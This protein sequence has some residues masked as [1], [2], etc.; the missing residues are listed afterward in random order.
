MSAPDSC[1]ERAHEQ[2]A[3]LVEKAGVDGRDDDEGHHQA[4]DA[5]DGSQAGCRRG[6]LVATRVVCD[7]QRPRDIDGGTR[8]P[9]D[10]ARDEDAR[11]VGGEGEAGHGQGAQ[12]RADGHR[13]QRTGPAGQ[14]TPDAEGQ[15][16][17]ERAHETRQGDGLDGESQAVHLHHRDEGRGGHHAAAEDQLGDRDAAQHGQTQDGGHRLARRV[18]V[19]IDVTMDPESARGRGTRDARHRD[20]GD[21]GEPSRP[22]R[23]R[24]GEEGRHA[25][26]RATRADEAE[27]PA[28]RGG[29]IERGPEALLEWPAQ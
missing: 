13:D 28:A 7:E 26:G 23:E 3:G 25:G 27:D 1:S 16:R 29:G 11:K 20:D 2:A 12:H 10:G 22:G 5:H 18:A 6:L 14:A 24:E 8:G 9:K 21:D 4:A 19:A 17:R 15:R